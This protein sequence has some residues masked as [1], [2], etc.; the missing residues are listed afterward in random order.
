[1]IEPIS[2][3]ESAIRDTLVMLIFHSTE[4]DETIQRSVAAATPVPRVG[5][6]VSLPVIE[7]TEDGA[8]AENQEGVYEVTN[9]ERTYSK[10]DIESDDSEVK[11]LLVHVEATVR[12]IE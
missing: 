4:S 6:R 8:S 10:F 12:S 9:I 5:E 1:M 11:G 7:V 3:G 2:D